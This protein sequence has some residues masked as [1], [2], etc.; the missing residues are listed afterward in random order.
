MVMPFFERVVVVLLSKRQMLVMFICRALK[1]WCSS[2]PTIY[3]GFW[4]F[5]DIVWRRRQKWGI[6]LRS[7]FLVSLLFL[8]TSTATFEGLWCV[9]TSAR[10]WQRA[11]A[12]PYTSS[13]KFELK[14]GLV[15]KQSSMWSRAVVPSCFHFRFRAM[16]C[17]SL[18]LGRTD[19]K[20]LIRHFCPVLG[21][22]SRPVIL[23]K[24]SIYSL[25]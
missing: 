8:Y 15:S 20:S 25:I 22:I 3:L 21:K 5:Y 12:S 6:N 4:C 7:F 1:K 13:L 24:L 14:R 23:I 10:I 11:M 19:W 17:R 16:S 9:S 18:L 2:L